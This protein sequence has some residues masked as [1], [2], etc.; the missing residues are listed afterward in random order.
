MRF[1]AFF[2]CAV[3]TARRNVSPPSLTRFRLPFTPSCQEEPQPSHDAPSQMRSFTSGLA[4]RVDHMPGDSSNQSSGLDLSEEFCRIGLGPVPYQLYVTG[5]PGSPLAGK[6]VPRQSPP[7]LK[8]TLSPGAILALFTRL[9]VRQAVAGPRP[10]AA[11]SPPSLST[12]QVAA[13]ADSATPSVA[14][15]IVLFVFTPS[16]IPY[17]VRERIETVKFTTDFP[18]PPFPLSRERVSAPLPQLEI[19]PPRNENMVRTKS[20]PLKF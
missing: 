19:A 6:S 13:A 18:D 7:R 1:T 9:S 12:C 14:I 16:I 4:M 3:H 11:S 10:S 17:F 5:L 8:S 2:G 20:S 15:M